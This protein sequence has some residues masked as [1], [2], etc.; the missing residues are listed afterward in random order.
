MTNRTSN[1]TATGIFQVTPINNLAINEK[2]ADWNKFHQKWADLSEPLRRVADLVGVREQFII[3]QLAGKNHSF[4][5]AET[6]NV[7]LRWTSPAYNETLSDSHAVPGRP[8]AL[9][10]SERKAD[11]PGV[12]RVQDK[13]RRPAVAPAASSHL[14]M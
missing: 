7:T 13:S 5:N 2:T 12:C 3:Q 8:G 14:C 4:S 11:C 1:V 6:M 9:R 10:T